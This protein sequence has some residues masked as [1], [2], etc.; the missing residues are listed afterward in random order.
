MTGWLRQGFLLSETQIPNPGAPLGL[1]GPRLC[2]MPRGLAQDSPTKKAKKTTDSGP[3]PTGGG[4][5]HAEL[6]LIDACSYIAR[7]T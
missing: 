7:C 1:G 4:Q 3:G 5:V 6:W 2:C